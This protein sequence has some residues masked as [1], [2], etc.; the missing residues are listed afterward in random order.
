[1][2]IF[3]A[4]DWYFQD[5]TFDLN[6]V[7]SIW[8]EKLASASARGY[9]GVRVTEIPLVHDP[10]YNE[11]HVWDDNEVVFYN[12]WEGETHRNHA[13]FRHRRAP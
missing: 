12:R 8:N 10:Y 9:A 1:V 3:A 7:I 4:R 2:E 5:G 6:R 11:Y 13:D